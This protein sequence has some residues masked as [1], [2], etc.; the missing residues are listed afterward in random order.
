MELY[1]TVFHRAWRQSLSTGGRPSNEAT[2]AIEGTIG[3]R[4]EP[5]PVHQMRL[6]HAMTAIVPPSREPLP[7]EHA[8]VP[9][10]RPPVPGL[11]PPRA[12]L[13]VVVTVLVVQPLDVA[14]GSCQG[15]NFLA[16]LT[17]VAVPNAIYNNHRRFR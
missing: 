8:A 7:V 5:L 16:R 9:V 15:L 12:V 3:T 6:E 1:G 13:A 4:A 2:V 10:R 14:S 17:P 11:P